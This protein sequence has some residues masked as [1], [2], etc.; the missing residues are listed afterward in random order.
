VGVPLGVKVGDT[1]PHEVAL[2]ESA[3][4]TPCPVVSFVRVAV[5]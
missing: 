1:E 3:H 5:N 2:H 4:L